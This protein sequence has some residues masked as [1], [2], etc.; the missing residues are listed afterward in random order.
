M[1]KEKDIEETHQLLNAQ[2]KRLKEVIQT[3]QLYMHTDY[4]DCNVL[5]PV[6]AYCWELQDEDKKIG[7]GINKIVSE[8]DE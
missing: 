5:C 6:Y 4:E 3:C 7:N 8:Q 2:K 1:I